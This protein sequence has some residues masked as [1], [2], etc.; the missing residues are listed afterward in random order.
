MKKLF[1]IFMILIFAGQ[2]ETANSQRRF[3]V[4]IFPTQ[5]STGLEIWESKF[6][7]YNVLEKK[8]SDYF[9]TLFKRSPLIDV[10]VLD[11]A[12]MNRWLSGPRRGDDM[13]VQLELYEAIMKERHVIGNVETGRAQLRLKIFDSA[14]VRQIATRT[15]QGKSKRFTFDSESDLFMFNA[16]IK[17]LPIPFD[18][19]L[20]LFGLTQQNYK[21]QKM[22]RLT[23]EQF[24][25]T[26]HWQSIKNAIDIAYREAM[27]QTGNVIRSNNPNAALTAEDNFSP[28]FVTIGRILSPTA[29]SKRRKRKYII[30]LGSQAQGS[31]EG[32][33][34]GEILDV[35]RSDTYVTVDPQNPV[36]VLPKT[37][38]KV[39]VIKVFEQN[40]IVQV[41]RDNKKEPITLKDMVIKRTSITR[42]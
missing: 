20:D 21:G 27:S 38:G 25:G 35:I 9:E 11:E 23:W 3:S 6:Y 32:V 31:L 26:S 33:R 41:I 1:L 4:V 19:G 36:V 15:T 5:N 10:R 22:S 24:K 12:G 2:A 42:R 8:M 37:I 17:R 14:M 30:S 34:V 13:A 7:P 39:K 18:D 28:S 29:D 40:A 16:A